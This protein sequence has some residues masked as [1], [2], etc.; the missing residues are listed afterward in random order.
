MGGSQNG[1]E[2]V[3]KDVLTAPHVPRYPPRYH[4]GG[5]GPGET[6]PPRAR[7]PGGGGGRPGAGRRGR[8]HR[9]RHARV[10][11]PDLGPAAGGREPNSGKAV[12]P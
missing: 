11:P 7:G 3:S 4:K 6:L 5:R 2:N 9:T 1:K 12:K 10:E 8:R